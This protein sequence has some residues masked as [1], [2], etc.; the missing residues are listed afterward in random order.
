M[1]TC[2]HYVKPFCEGVP[3]N[4]TIWAHRLYMCSEC[5]RF[6]SLLDDSVGHPTEEK[7]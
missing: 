4:A 1:N 3:T 7:S 5:K 6:Y 2:K